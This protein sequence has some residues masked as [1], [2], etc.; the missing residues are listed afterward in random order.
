MG[1]VIVGVLIF[2]VVV[3]LAWFDSVTA[4]GWE[5]EDGFHYGKKERKINR[6]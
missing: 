2:L 6:R 3:T 5:D 1:W 4:E